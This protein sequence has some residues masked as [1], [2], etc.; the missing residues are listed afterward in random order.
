MFQNVRDRLVN[1]YY[2]LVNIL[3]VVNNILFLHFS[4]INCF[5]WFWIRNLNL[6]VLRVQG[7][8]LSC[9]FKI[10]IGF[11]FAKRDSSLSIW[12]FK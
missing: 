3:P 5:V 1:R 9:L 2:H 12:F 6:N 4:V 11:I 8:A 7:F 10:M